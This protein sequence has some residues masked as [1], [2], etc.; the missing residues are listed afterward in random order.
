MTMGKWAQKPK[1]AGEVHGSTKTSPE[2]EPHLVNGTEHSFL[3]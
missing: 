1:S 3:R 2:G